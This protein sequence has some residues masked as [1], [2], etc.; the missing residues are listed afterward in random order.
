MHLS[1]NI[2]HCLRVFSVNLKILL[3][4]CLAVKKLISYEGITD[5]FRNPAAPTSNN[6]VLSILLER[7]GGKQRSFCLQYAFE[8]IVGTGHETHSR[9]ARTSA[10]HSTIQVQQHIISC[11]HSTP[12]LFLDMA[13]AARCLKSTISEIVRYLRKYTH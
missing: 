8:H 3:V 12:H 2:L 6:I 4:L 5:W 1:C 9:P 7:S 11:P 10:Y 13:Y